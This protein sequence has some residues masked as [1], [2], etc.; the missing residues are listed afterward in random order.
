MKSLK[1]QDL[2]V[3]NYVIYK[4]GIAQVEIV[5]KKKVGI[6]KKTKY[7]GSLEAPH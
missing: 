6:S 1:A 5:S 4:E 2:R 7:E 3:G